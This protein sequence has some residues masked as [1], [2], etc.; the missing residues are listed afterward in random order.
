MLNKLHSKSAAEKYARMRA[1]KQGLHVRFYRQGDLESPFSDGRCLH[2]TKPNELWTNEQWD[3]WYYE[4]NHEIG[5]EAEVNCDPHWKH[6]L[7]HYGF[8]GRSFF[9]CMMNLISDHIQEHNQIGELD[10]VD[11][12]LMLGRMRFVK[13]RL[14]PEEVLA[15]PSKTREGAVFK[16]VSVYDTLCRSEWNRHLVGMAEAC[17]MLLEGEELEMYQALVDSDIAIDEGKNEWDT[18]TITKQILELLGEDV[19]QREEEAQNGSEEGEGECEEGEGGSSSGDDDG[20]EGS[21]GSGGL[22][23]EAAEEIENLT[24]HKHPTVMEYG[25]DSD[26]S[27]YSR[28]RQDGTI[29]YNEDMSG[30]GDI[31]YPSQG[32]IIDISKGERMPNVHLSDSWRESIVK[33]VNAISGGE[34]LTRNVRKLIQARKNSMWQNNLRAGRLKSSDLWRATKTGGYDQDIY[35][36]KISRI[37]KSTAVCVLTDTSGSMMGSKYPHAVK[38]NMMLHKAFGQAGVPLELLSFSDDGSNSIHMVMSPFSERKVS[39]SDLLNRYGIGASYSGQNADGEA[40]QWAYSRL[41][42][43]K[44]DRLVL[45]VLSDGQPSCA[46]RGSYGGEVTHTKKVVNQID[47]Y[48]PV[49]IYGIGIMDNSVELFYNSFSVINDA[50]ELEVALMSVV[51]NKVL[52]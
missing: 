18:Y 25:S 14:C 5:H 6:V 1:G 51:K 4:L 28:S 48:T 29:H 39:D 17:E 12:S 7:E 13:E 26:K 49:E 33:D 2:L 21:Q 27:G 34:L 19:Q 32:V 41:V 42:R 24:Q 44:E 31:Y 11:R 22:S 52:S 16:V 43:R 20:D 40:I 30:Y 8:K 10:G 3:E 46:T 50:A 15:E 9:T 23:K 38:A 47:K 45:I 35:R 36:K 37:D